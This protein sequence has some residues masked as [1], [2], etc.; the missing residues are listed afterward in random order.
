METEY[1]N[2]LLDFHTHSTSSDGSCTPSELVAH[3]KEKGVTCLALTDHNTTS[4]LAEFA[5]A[6]KSNNILAI[7]FGVE[8]YAELPAGLAKKGENDSPDLVIL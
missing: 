4:G 6:C 7:P 1:F 5:V 3:A 2:G 8:I